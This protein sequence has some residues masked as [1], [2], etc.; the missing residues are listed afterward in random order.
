M[1]FEQRK[2]Y[3]YFVN[4]PLEFIPLEQFKDKRLA[5][6]LPQVTL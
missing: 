4:S 5:V 1:H 6:S 2:S 3:V